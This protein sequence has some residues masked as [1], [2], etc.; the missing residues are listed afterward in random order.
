MAQ[1]ILG[2][3]QNGQ[4]Q[5][6]KLDQGKFFTMTNLDIHSDP[7]IA[8]PQLALTEEDTTPNE[9]CFN[10]IA[11]NGDIYFC[12]KTTGKIWKRTSAGD[13]SLVH[14]NA[15][16]AHR[17]CQ[18]FNGYLWFWTATKLGYFDLAS[19]WVDS[20]ATFSN[21]NARGSVEANNTLLIG[22]GKYVARIDSANAFSANELTIPAM[23]AVTDM[24]SVGDDVLIGTY[25]GT[26]VSFCKVFLWN[27]VDSSWSVE[28]S[29]YEIGVN[30]FL[31]VDN[32]WM[33]QCG[34]QGRIYYWTGS[35]LAYFGKIRGATTALGE[36]MTANFKGRAL[37]AIGDTIYSIHREDSTFPYAICG[38]YTATDTIN[39]I[40]VSG[41]NL[42]A[43][44]AS[45]VDKTSTSYAT[46]VIETPEIQA[47]VTTLDVDY[48]TYAAG[49]T[50]ETKLNN[51]SYVAQ[52]ER[53][54]SV[55]MKVLIDGG[56]D[57]NAVFQG[58]IILTPSGASVPKIKKINIT[59]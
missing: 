26:N 27:T 22:D 42:F 41:T 46:A 30:N 45:G 1:L 53:V 31:Q 36:Q 19:T 23:Y 52:T 44:T 20:F 9:T 7:G 50:V 12:S 49:V 33:A 35:Q 15:N 34:T 14:T 37:I 21:S 10:A 58:K 28:D 17:G 54:D 40:Q 3:F 59:I 51:G 25:V 2:E 13:Y 47:K 4:T 16:T 56:T 8:Q 18:Y 55:A 43:D 6:G 39:S 5:L 29:V 48:D 57:E 24:V 32:I 11:P 38:E